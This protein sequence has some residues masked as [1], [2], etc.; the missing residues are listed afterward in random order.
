MYIWKANL[1]LFDGTASGGE[2]AA[3]AEGASQE[4]TAAAA[5]GEGPQEQAQETQEDRQA[6]YNQLLAEFKDLDEARVNDVI[7]KRT[8]GVRQAA[9]QLEALQAA[10]APLYAAHGLEPGDVEG[11]SRTIADDNT[12]WERGAEDAGMSVEQY[13]QMQLMAM[14][15]QRLQRAIGQQ[16]AE[17]A[18][19]RQMAAWQQEAEA[20]KGDYPDFDLM[21]EIQ[22]P[23]F[24]SLITSKNEATRLSL[25]AAYEAC[26]VE[27][28]RQAA[29]RSAAQQA[30]HNVTHTIAA[31]GKRPREG[32]A[33]GNPA[34]SPG[35]I[36]IS[37]LTRAQMLA[38][39][40][41]AERGERITL[42]EGSL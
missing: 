9:S 30:E 28:L 2:G 40:R 24:V 7:Q 33:G 42:T 41:R 13:K 34:A 22:N 4:S 36:D 39:E 18:A 35:R 8:R 23:L 15:N 3:G 21:A 25:K 26:H 6:R 32:G 12:Y 29:A 38:L 16:A 10:I 31:N 1:H 19:N 11:L 27:E 5:Q 37:K 14:E 17:E 20:L